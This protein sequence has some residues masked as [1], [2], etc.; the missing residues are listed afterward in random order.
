M[1]LG[2]M[3]G[4]RNALTGSITRSIGTSGDFATFAQFWSWINRNTFKNVD[5]TLN[6]QAGTHYMPDEEICL[7]QLNGFKNVNIVGADMATTILEW[8]IPAALVNMK[9]LR[10]VGCDSWLTQLT[11]QANAASADVWALQFEEGCYHQSRYLTL[12]GFDAAVLA[13]NSWL[14]LRDVD[15]VAPADGPDGQSIGVYARSECQF[16]DVTVDN[17]DG[18]LVGVTCSHSN[19]VWRGANSISNCQDGMAVLWNCRVF[20]QGT[21]SFTSISR[22]NYRDLGTG[23]EVLPGIP[24]LDG[25]EVIAATGATSGAGIHVCTTAAEI[26]ALPNN[27]LYVDATDS[28]QV[29]T[30]KFKNNSGASVT[31]T[32]T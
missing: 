1:G 2:K 4:G 28:P 16:R 24:A 22:Y 10:F 12:T 29:F 6:V 14:Y 23:L 27:S 7:G 17:N 19:I 20:V 9:G 18:S 21:L 8:N 5:L 26:T 3:V 30:L 11:L 15:I 25:S 32:V 31:V 13:Y